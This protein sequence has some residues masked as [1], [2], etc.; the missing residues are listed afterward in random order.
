MDRVYVDFMEG[1]PDKPFVAGSFFHGNNATKLGGGEGN[2][3][4]AISDKANN[5]IQLNSVAGIRAQ[6]QT[7]NYTHWD[8]AGNITIQSFESIKLICKP[9]NGGGNGCSIEMDKDGK[10]SIY[11]N[12]I[13]INAKNGKGDAKITLDSE[14][15][16]FI[17]SSEQTELKETP[18]IKIKG[19]QEVDIN[20]G[21]A[22]VLA[23]GG[24]VHI[25]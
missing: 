1:N 10:V 17:K 4:R 19:T 6:D 15:Y 25:N 23:K 13:S 5:Y 7:G 14:K 2:H 8:G 24:I 11:G 16:T 3:V 9:Q 22:T 12:D 20:G 21:N 18:I